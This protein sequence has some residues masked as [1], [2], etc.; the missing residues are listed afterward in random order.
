MRITKFGHSCVRVEVAGTTLV[1]DPGAFSEP[2]AVDGA[3]AV[4]LTHEHADPY[5]V[6]RVRRAGAPIWTHASLAEALRADAP[7]LAERVHVVEPGVAVTVGAVTVRPVGEWHAVIHPELPRVSNT[8]FVLDAEGVSAYHP[9]DA[10]TVPGEDVD[11]LLLP[12]TAPWSKVA[13]TIDFARE[14]GA[15]LTVPIHE[16]IFSTPGLGVIDGH[17]QRFLGERG[18]DYRRVDVGQDV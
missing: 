16:A 9:G 4:L 18:L 11:V 15:P 17:L 5:E 14:V 10:L 12:A 6:E 3:D 13:E 7:D 2:E 1:L 8:G